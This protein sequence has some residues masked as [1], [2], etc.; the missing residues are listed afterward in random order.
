M[1]VENLDDVD[2]YDAELRRHNVHFRAAADVRPGDHVVDIGCGTGRTTREAARA[3]GNGSALGVDVSAPALER[4]RR[5]A[6][7]EGLRNITFAHG[8]AQSHRFSSAHFDLCISRF[9]TM[10]FTDPIAAFTNI[11][12]ALRPG[13][14]LV[15]LVW[16]D[17]DRNEWFTAVRQ[18][19]AGSTPPS[20]TDGDLEPFSLAD[21]ARTQRLLTAA[22]FADVA[23]TA[24]HE[25][26]SYGPDPHAAYHAVLGLKHAVDLLARLDPATRAGAADRLRAT[27]VAHHAGSG[28]LFDSRAWIVTGRRT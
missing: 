23:F 14:R 15:L 8:D 7:A 10:F 27:L 2:F 4:A 22:G 1:T 12:R 3:A 13:A 5:I 25:P 24:V 11:G 6:A 19:L 20:P 17:A 21:P 16:Q 26:V 9:G 18:A 28:V